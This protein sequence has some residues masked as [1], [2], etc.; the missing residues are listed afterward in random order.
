MDFSCAPPFFFFCFLLFKKKQTQFVGLDSEPVRDD[1][2][3]YLLLHRHFKRLR[4]NKHLREAKQIF[5]PENN[6]GM[7]SAHLDTMVNDIP[8]VETFWEKDNRPGV[9][10]D[11]KATRGYQFML[12]NCLAQ[13]S[14]HFDMDLFTVTREK[15][16]QCMK[17][18]L[19]DQ[20]LRYHWEKKATDI[21]GK[22]RFSLTGKVGNKQ[23]DLLIAMSMVP[24]WGRIIMNDRDRLST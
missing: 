13:G 21:M 16:P 6:L 18:L 22:D 20:M 14:I 8:G 10:K 12:S 15:T 1:R 11:G 2:E 9:C 17:D 24:Y 5:I 23:D 7:E 19:L 3:E 4:E